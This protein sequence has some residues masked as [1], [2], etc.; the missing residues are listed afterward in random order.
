M[1]ELPRLFIY[2]HLGLCRRCGL[3]NSP[4]VLQ[5]LT[6]ISRVIPVALTEASLLH[7][8]CSYGN[9]TLVHLL[10]RHFPQLLY[11]KTN[12][13]Y[14]PFH[15]A[16]AHRQTDILQM[17][18]NTLQHR[19]NRTGSNPPLPMELSHSRG[20]AT[21][22]AVTDEPLKLV[23]DT[24]SGHT[25]LHFAAC[26]NDVLSLSVLLENA[27]DLEIDDVNARGCGYSPLHLA[28]H[29]NHYDSALRLLKAK[30]KPNIY[31]RDS[32]LNVFSPTP[33]AEATIQG[34]VPMVRLLVKSGA[35]DKKHEALK[36]CLQSKEGNELI[37]ILLSSLV[38]CDETATKQRLIAQGRREGKKLRMAAADWGKL[39]M[40]FL[41]PEWILT[42]FSICPFFTNQSLEP[43]MS[44]EYVT[45]LNLQDNELKELPFE[46]FQLPWLLSLNV[47]G[48]C[49]TT[50]PSLEMRMNV[51][52]G[53]MERPCSNLSRLLLGKNQLTEVPEFLFQLP[54]LQYLELSHNQIKH[55]PLAIW[56]A[57]MLTNLNCAHNQIEEIPTNWPHILEEYTFVDITAAPSSPPPTSNPTTR[58]NRSSGGARTMPSY[59]SQESVGAESEE[60][61]EAVTIERARQTRLYD[62]L[63]VCNANLTIE[64]T[65]GDGRDNSHD[66]LQILNLS[67]N[68]I[69][70]IPE[71]FP[72]LCPKLNRLDLSNNKIS[73]LLLP[74][75]VP[76][77]LRQLNISHNEIEVLDSLKARLPPHPCTNPKVLANS[78]G[79]IYVDPKV[80][81]THRQH[82]H[83]ISLS[84]L[85]ASNNSITFVRLYSPIIS[86]SGGPC[87]P[88]GRIRE[89]DVPL[90][91]ALASASGRSADSVQQLAR[92][93]CPLL[94]RLV[95]QHN[96]IGD[97]PLSVCEM[98]SL[99]SLDLSH[100]NIIELR[101]ELG[102][103]CN[104]WE[105]PLEGLQLISPPH[106]I[107]E[108]GKTK[109]I[110][111]FLW[112]LLQR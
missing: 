9:Q 5:V 98:T 51:Y 7:A 55:L 6:Q 67:N 29:L 112:S 1:K 107:I 62:R 8:A 102:K 25:A 38:K 96:E 12:E 30:A 31:L 11:T 101:P 45:N 104:L 73:K 85:D 103:L 28:V 20:R 78:N 56:S 19:K 39:K 21:T 54:S 108:R 23:S 61:D 15:I 47:S 26:L 106:N 105:F 60:T 109:D 50:I 100:N 48:N 57:P 89:V 49:L 88:D 83:L 4:E 13:G 97:V 37:P 17:M 52:T 44:L 36:L 79:T 75:C 59:V 43:P 10:L 41:D 84:V 27:K 82:N 110:I 90:F 53:V 76:S 3:L 34:N 22:A 24:A 95:L 18:I 92:L 80:Y 81:C 2:L 111:G 69:T 65:G 91:A 42:S 77:G 64:W 99:N 63:N 94:T 14:T 35:E 58:T 32:N 66:G 33:L 70:E 93:A 87:Q 74:R 46:V 71:N 68:F 40:G 16:V 72:C 86:V